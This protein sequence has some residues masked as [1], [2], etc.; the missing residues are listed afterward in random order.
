MIARLLRLESE[1]VWRVSGWAD[2]S[3]E[4]PV[5]EM[6]NTEAD[7]ATAQPNLIK[8]AGFTNIAK[9]LSLGRIELPG[10]EDY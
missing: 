8:D 3:V 7:T 10:V 2:A 5:G 6:A 4:M 1:A 9:F